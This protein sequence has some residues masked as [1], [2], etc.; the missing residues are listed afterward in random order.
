MGGRLA[1]QHAQAGGA[2][3]VATYYATLGPGEP[4]IIPCPV[5]LHWAES[6]SWDEGQEPEAFM[7][8]LREHG[9]PVTSHTYLGT[10]HSF[11]NASLPDRVDANAAALAFVRTALFMQEHLQGG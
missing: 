11:A 8:R 7:G 2:D 6:D 3:A 4:G 1:L 9:T 5:L 10:R